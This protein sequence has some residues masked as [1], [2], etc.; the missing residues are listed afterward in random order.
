MNYRPSGGALDLAPTAHINHWSCLTQEGESETDKPP[1]STHAH[2]KGRLRLLE[3]GGWKKIKML[4][5]NQTTSLI[6]CMVK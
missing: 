4:Y 2:A 3:G 6:I 1:Q 5:S